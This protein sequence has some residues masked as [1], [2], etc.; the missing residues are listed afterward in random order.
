MRHG[1]WPRSTSKTLAVH[2]GGGRLE[3]AK[4]R[5]RHH[6]AELLA[7]NSAEQ[8]EP[9]ERD[10]LRCGRKL[11]RGVVLPVCPELGP[12]RARAHLG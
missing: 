3:S 1:N 6:R 12:A 10:R 8:L 11:R 2:A 9:R 7:D 4:H 5:R